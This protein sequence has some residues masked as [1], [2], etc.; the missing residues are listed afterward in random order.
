MEQSNLHAFWRVELQM[1]HF[2]LVLNK[3]SQQTLDVRFLQEKVVFVEGDFV[4]AIRV[5]LVPDLLERVS[6]GTNTN[7]E[8]SFVVRLL[9]A[10]RTIKWAAAA[11]GQD[12]V[13]RQSLLA[14]E[15]PGH[16]LVALQIEFRIGRPRNLASADHIS[17]PN[18]RR[19]S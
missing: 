10:V 7:L 13:P 17:I 18:T 5:V 16:L 3:Q 6:R 1:R 12:R 9:S 19:A 14:F 2:V 15:R 8:A 4:H 11:G